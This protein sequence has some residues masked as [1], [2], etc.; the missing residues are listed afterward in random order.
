[1]C[2][3][4]DLVREQMLD[5]LYDEASPSDRREME[6]HLESCDTCRLEIR[7]LRRVREDL[8][9]WDVPE[10]SSVWTPFA[11]VAVI[12]WFRQ[13]PSWAMAVAA[14]VMFVVGVAGGGVGA[15][16]VG[17]DRAFTAR[18]PAP[19][20]VANVPELSGTSQARS[21]IGP[22][23]IGPDQI[24][25]DQID[26]EMIGSMVRTALTKSGYD[27]LRSATPV[28]RTSS[29]PMRPDPAMRKQLED[30]A[31]SLIGSSEAR[32]WEA[33]Q[34]YL[35]KVANENEWQRRDDARRI[36]ALTVQVEQLQA[37]LNQVALQLTR[38]Q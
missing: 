28:S 32:Q 36:N 29:G 25:P 24:D 1:M 20:S 27:P 26:P 33:I 12:P 9:A 2:N 8:L 22:D 37:G 13:V 14:S 4:R 23:Q 30:F 16:L 38:V 21:Q 6:R 5:C 17:S 10:Q 31:Q 15:S 35:L 19:S 11:P 18:T 34:Q 3:Q 7:S